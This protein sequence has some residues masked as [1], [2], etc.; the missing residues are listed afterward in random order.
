[1]SF[2]SYLYMVL[3]SLRALCFCFFSSFEEFI[4]LGVLHLQSFYILCFSA[5]INLTC[6]QS[7]LLVFSYVS[8]Q[9]ILTSFWPCAFLDTGFS[10]NFFFLHKLLTGF[11]KTRLLLVNLSV[12]S[13]F[14][15]CIKRGALLRPANSVRGSCLSVLAL[16]VAPLARLCW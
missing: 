1:M 2:F 5:L 16:P 6:V 9:F 13:A 3:L 15:S 14:G 8:Y 4:V 7:V 11:N 10:S 12:A